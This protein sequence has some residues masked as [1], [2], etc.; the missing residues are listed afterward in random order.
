MSVEALGIKVVNLEKLEQTWILS[1]NCAKPENHLRRQRIAEP[2][3][4]ADKI[5]RI[6]QETKHHLLIFKV[7]VRDVSHSGLDV[8]RVMHHFMDKSPKGPVFLGRVSA[9]YTIVCSASLP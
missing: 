7:L 4:V 6:S 3:Y 1:A 9:A 8:E 5:S 2:P